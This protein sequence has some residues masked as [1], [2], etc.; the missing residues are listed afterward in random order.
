MPDLELMDDVIRYF[1]G[2]ATGHHHPKENV[3]YQY[4]IAHRPSYGDKVYQLLEDHEQ[5]A[6]AMAE[7]RI[8]FEAFSRVDTSSRRKL[9]EQ[10]RAFLDREANHMQREERLFFPAAAECLTK[11][12]WREVEHEQRKTFL[13]VTATRDF[14]KMMDG[15]L[16]RALRPNRA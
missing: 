5:M 2:Y 16:R 9:S 11:N 13:Q 7:L 6:V 12:Q 8:V 4:L 15:I 10:G 1:E 14:G 3:I